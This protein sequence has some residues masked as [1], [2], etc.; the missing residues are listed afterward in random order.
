MFVVSCAHI[1]DKPAKLRIQEKDLSL[2][3]VL[4]LSR[5]SFQKGCVDGMKYQYPLKTYGKNFEACLKMAKDHESEIKE[6][7]E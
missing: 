3:S 6:I 2:Q 5:T 4:D 1:S 7:L